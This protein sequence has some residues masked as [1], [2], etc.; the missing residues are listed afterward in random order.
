MIVG[1]ISRHTDDF[2]YGFGIAIIHRLFP[3]HD[4]YVPPYEPK[5]W[6]EV[7]DATHRSKQ[8]M[9]DEAWRCR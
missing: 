2:W 5:N 1:P 3:E 8:I 6:G 4:T 7:W 9:L